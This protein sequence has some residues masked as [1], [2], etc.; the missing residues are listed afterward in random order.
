MRGLDP[1]IDRIRKRSIDCPALDNK[2]AKL[3]V[4]NVVATHPKFAALFRKARSKCQSQTGFGEAF[5][6]F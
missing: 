6:F 5:L 2:C 1:R 4:V 3:S